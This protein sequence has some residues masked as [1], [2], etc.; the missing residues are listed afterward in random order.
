M[1]Y[2]IG[3]GEIWLTFTLLDN[4]YCVQDPIAV[5]INDRKCFVFV[6]IMSLMLPLLCLELLLSSATYT[7]L[8]N[9]PLN[10]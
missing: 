9:R 6:I 3:L 7:P 2:R 1:F 5:K 4:F 8:C 10:M